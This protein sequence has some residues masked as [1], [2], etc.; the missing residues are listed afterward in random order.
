MENIETIQNIMNKKRGRKPKGDIN[1]KNRNQKA[2]NNAHRA[3]INE[4]RR[5]LVKCECCDIIITKGSMYEHIK[6]QSHKLLLRI[7]ELENK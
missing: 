7:K 3:K 1:D 4:D 6:C 2:Y 5:Q